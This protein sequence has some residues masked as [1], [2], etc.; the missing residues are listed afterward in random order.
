MYGHQRK[1]QYREVGSIE[2]ERKDGKGKEGKRQKGG[3]LGLQRAKSTH[4]VGAV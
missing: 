2:K 4:R 3:E 1:K